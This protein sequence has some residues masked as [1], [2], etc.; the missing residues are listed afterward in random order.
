MLRN[1]QIIQS[2]KYMK[3]LR[4]D[5]HNFSVNTHV[6]SEVYFKFYHYIVYIANEGHHNEE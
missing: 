1:Q 5:D 3:S 2:P 4:N 6:R